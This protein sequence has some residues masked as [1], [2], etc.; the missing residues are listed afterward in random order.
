MSR[1]ILIS[2]LLVLLLASVVCMIN[3]KSV[4][5]D[6]NIAINFSSYTVNQIYNG[7]TYDS[8]NSGY[9][10]AIVNLTITNNGYDSFDTDPLYFSATT[11]NIGY[12]IDFDTYTLKNWNTESILNGG[13]FSG[14]LV[15]QIP[16]GTTIQ[17]MSYS[18]FT[19]TYQ[20]YNIVWNGQASTPTITPTQVANAPTSNPTQVT[21]ATPVAPE[22]PV[23]A[24]LGIFL[25]L[26]LFAVTVLTI[27]KPKISKN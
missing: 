9:T 6:N 21:T 19:S 3:I 5:A 7:F 22:F 17:S 15:F 23:I 14:A 11:N 12:N 25:L 27:R 13:S 8:P 1:K 4:K 26:S 10:Y 20:N 2:I 24:V 18:G 16:V